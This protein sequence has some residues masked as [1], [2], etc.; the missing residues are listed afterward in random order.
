MQI[1]RWV[2]GRLIL[3]FDWIFTPKGIK[4]DA[5]LQAK[6]DQQTAGLS[7][8][9]YPACPFCVKVRR[10]MKRNS[11]NIK[12]VNAKTCEYSKKELESG[13]GKLKVPCL[14]IENNKGEVNWMYESSDIITY[15]ENEVS[16]LQAA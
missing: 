3:L 4:R 9:Q 5:E 8:Y 1:I 12:T 7:L 6:I 11:L 10:A 16:E 2:L 13:G 14:R 15:L